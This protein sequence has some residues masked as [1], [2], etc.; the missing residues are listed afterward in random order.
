MVAETTAMVEVTGE[1][2]A[3]EKEVEKVVA[4]VPMCRRRSSAREELT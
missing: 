3:K 1:A 4:M 2:M